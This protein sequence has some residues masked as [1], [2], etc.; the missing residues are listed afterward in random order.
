MA[1]SGQLL[2]KLRQNSLPGLEQDDLDLL[3]LHVAVAP[4]RLPDKG[5]YL[6]RHLDAGVAAPRYNEGQQLA[7]LFRIALNL[8]P[9]QNADKVVAQEEGVSQGLEGAYSPG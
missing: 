5:V 4:G 3:R 1:E 7:P 9:L 2:G 8:R 6:R